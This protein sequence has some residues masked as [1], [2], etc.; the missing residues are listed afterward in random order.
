M[1][2]ITHE[3]QDHV[4]GLTPTNFPGLKVGKVWFA[5]TENPKDDVANQLR[6]KFKDR[7]L[8]LIDA[9]A[10]LT[11]L[12][13]NAAAAKVDWYLEFELGEPT[14]DFNGANIFPRREGSAQSANKRR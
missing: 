12:G 13:L 9:R 8:G 11:G 4:N 1:A 10:S 14:D 3:H 7:L 6:K 2:I 5:W